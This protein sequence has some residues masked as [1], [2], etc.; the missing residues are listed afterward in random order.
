[1]DCGYKE[2]AIALDFDH[3]PGTEKVHDIAYMVGSRTWTAIIE[4]IA[5]C[6]VV[7]SNCHRVR[8][9]MRRGNHGNS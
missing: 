2:H 1:M 9:Y 7:C 5:K 4:E 8:T 6:D 3:R